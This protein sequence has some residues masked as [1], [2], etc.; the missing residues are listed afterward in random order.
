MIFPITYEGAYINTKIELDI[1][2]IF[3][4]F[5]NI[6]WFFRRNI[7]VVLEK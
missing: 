6:S 2:N 4:L 7:S 5:Q 1:D 3:Y